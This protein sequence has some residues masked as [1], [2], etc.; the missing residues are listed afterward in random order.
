MKIL[1]E[2]VDKFKFL[3]EERGEQVLQDDN[4]EEMVQL[5][6]KLELFCKEF[7][8]ENQSLEQRLREQSVEVEKFKVEVTKKEELLVYLLVEVEGLKLDLSFV[9]E[10]LKKF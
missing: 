1:I 9:I 6:E 2:E 8:E 10:E 7:R 4:K 3:L 5:V